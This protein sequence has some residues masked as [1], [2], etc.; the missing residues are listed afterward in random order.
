MELDGV[1]MVPKRKDF[2]VLERINSKTWQ[3]VDIC[4]DRP[5]IPFYFGEEIS[6]DLS[7]N[8]NMMFGY[9]VFKVDSEIA[10]IAKIVYLKRKRK[11]ED[12]LH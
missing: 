9:E 6:N 11:N 8:M 5:V 1:R 7:N 10:R 2:I 4:I 12:S 3:I